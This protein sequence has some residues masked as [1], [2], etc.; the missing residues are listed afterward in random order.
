MPTRVILA[1]DHQIIRGGLRLLLEKYPEFEVIG[2]AGNGREAIELARKLTPD[3][4]IMDVA[5][6]DLNGIQATHR[7]HDECP[8]IKIIALTAHTDKN[9]LTGMLQAGTSGY[10]LKDC[11]P[12]E[13]VQAIRSVIQGK[14]YVSPD[15]TSLIIQDYRNRTNATEATVDETLT[16]KE[17]EVL[18]MISEGTGTKEI[19]I[20]L[21]QSAKTVERLRAQI[22]AKL[23]VFTVAELT[24]YAVRHGLTSLE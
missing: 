20:R 21:Q 22:M 15:I 5:M 13:L 12:G 4:I 8:D 18:Q 19:A 23:G 1:D 6:P 11:A 3:V 16:P 2:E 7:I 14:A 10:L 9:Y 17:K 24:K